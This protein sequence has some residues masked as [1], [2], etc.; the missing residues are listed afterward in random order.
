MGLL[1][2]TDILIREGFIRIIIDQ[3]ILK[4]YTMDFSL[5][6]KDFDNELKMK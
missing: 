4:S 5:L 3:R 6:V 1:T 2:Q